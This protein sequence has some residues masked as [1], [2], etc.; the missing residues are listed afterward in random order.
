MARR[1]LM[2]SVFNSICTTRQAVDE[3]NDIIAV[4]AVIGVDAQLVNDLKVVLAPVLEVDQHVVQRGAVLALEIAVFA[5]GFG[6]LEDISVDDLITQ[7]G[8]F[9]VGEADAVE[10]LE[11]IAEVLVQRGLVT[12]VRA[13]AVL[14]LLELF[15]NFLLN[16]AFFQSHPVT[17]SFVVWYHVSEAALRFSLSTHFNLILL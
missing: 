5:Q 16:L 1:G 3:Q 9:G 6:S 15:D 17:T 13:I 12:D 14:E 10:G 2:P 8:E 11:L 4:V 7:S